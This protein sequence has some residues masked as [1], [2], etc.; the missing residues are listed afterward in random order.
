[1]NGQNY[2]PSRAWSN[3]QRM[4]HDKGTVLT[5]SE[6]KELKDPRRAELVAALDER[7][8]RL[9]D[10]TLVRASELEAI[11]SFWTGD[12]ERVLTAQRLEG[13]DFRKSM[14]D[15]TPLDRVQ[16]ALGRTGA[17][18]SFLLT[19]GLTILLGA[20]GSGKSIAAAA[21]ARDIDAEHIHYGEPSC[22]SIPGSFSSLAASVGLGIQRQLQKGR[23]V[24]RLIIDSFKSVMY[25]DTSALRSGGISAR[26]GEMMSQLAAS[27]ER[28]SVAI[29]VTLNP[30]LE[31]DEVKAYY[32]YLKGHVTAVMLLEHKSRTSAILTATSRGF[33][34]RP[35]F[36][37]AVAWTDKDIDMYRE[38]LG[39]GPLPDIDPDPQDG[40]P[41]S[42]RSF[43]SGAAQ[44][45]RNG[46]PSAP[47]VHAADESFGLLDDEEIL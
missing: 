16:I 37:G 12:A 42:P 6:V 13:G 2:G 33:G 1:V 39:R 18:S 27:A 44:P 32:H 34:A 45:L 25:A 47:A 36:S 15:Y 46:K 23:L 29:V 14:V 19:S 11:K 40:P 26:F 7:V 10:M 8:I 30:S 21:L 4:V 5:E 28:M 35:D 38:L 9:P 41:S 17:M 22:T 43:P 3:R 20:Q 24:P 31:S